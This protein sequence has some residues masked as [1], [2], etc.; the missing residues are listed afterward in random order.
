MNILLTNDDGF[1]SL[2]IRTLKELLSKY[3]TVVIVAPDSQ[4]SANSAS[5]SIGHPLTIDKVEEGVYKCNGTPVDCVSMG[6]C[7][8]DMKFDLVVSGCN[9]GYNISYDTMYSGT[10]GAALESLIFRIPSIAVSAPHGSDFEVV[11]KYFDQVWKYIFDNELTSKEIYILSLGVAL[12]W[13]KKQLD[14]VT[15]FRLHLSNKDFKS[16]SEQ[17]NLQRRLERLGAMEEDLSEE[18]TK[19]QIANLDKLPYFN[20]G[21]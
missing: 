20:G 14:D 13:Y 2:G 15:Q 19:Y 12:G 9:N 11:R 3:G 18:I 8:L 1:D 10:V 5:L 6:L 17:Q 21:A 7:L 16:Y 4:R